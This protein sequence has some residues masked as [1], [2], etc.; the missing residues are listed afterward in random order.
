[1]EGLVEVFRRLKIKIPKKIIAILIV[2]LLLFSYLMIDSAVKPTIFQLSE[3]KLKYLAIQAMNN[4]VTEAIHGVTYNDLITILKDGEGRITMMQINALKMTE[5]ASNAA[6]KAQ[7][8][9]MNLGTQGIYIP[10]G[11]IIGGQILT[12]KGPLI[13]ID[14]VPMGSVIA[15]YSTSLESAG[16]NQTSNKI[17]MTLTANIQIVVGNTGRLIEVDQQ[18]LIADNIIVGNV[19]QTFLQSARDELLQLVPPSD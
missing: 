8:T 14:I 11:T 3:S 10:L 19:P 7:D 1:M 2:C 12:G 6:L 9:I 15:K 4:A 16:I 13:R 5:L 17:Y 18:A